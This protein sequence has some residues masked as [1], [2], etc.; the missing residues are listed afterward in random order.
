MSESTVEKFVGVDVSKATLDIC[1]MPPGQAMHVTYDDAG[2]GHGQRGL[3]P[4][5]GQE[6]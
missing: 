5:Q 2:I 1:I 6:G 3:T 4:F